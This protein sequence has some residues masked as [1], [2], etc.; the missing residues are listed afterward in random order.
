[1]RKC[2]DK[3]YRLVHSL[4]PRCDLKS[5]LSLLS[6][7]CRVKLHQID[8][9]QSIDRKTKG[10]GGGGGKMSVPS[11]SSLLVSVI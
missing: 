6:F 7:P 3:Y 9:K 10:R 1:M 8:A 5:M 11:A 2:Y 4:L